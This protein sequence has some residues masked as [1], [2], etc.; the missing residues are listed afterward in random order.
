[1]LV[2]NLCNTIKK[3]LLA[4]WF[5]KMWNVCAALGSGLAMRSMVNKED[6]LS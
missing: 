2:P 4:L 6:V 3:W 1:M 5:L